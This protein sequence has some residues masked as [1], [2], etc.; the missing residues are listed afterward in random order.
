MINVLP[1]YRCDSIKS[2]LHKYNT[3]FLNELRFSSLKAYFR[4]ERNS[5]CNIKAAYLLVKYDGKYVNILSKIRSIVK[6]DSKQQF[7]TKTPSLFKAPF[8][9]TSKLHAKLLYFPL[10]YDSY[11]ANIFIKIQARLYQKSIRA[12][13]EKMPGTHRKVFLVYKHAHKKLKFT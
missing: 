2:L 10:K 11:Y 5:K 3:S 7:C 1:K 6:N 13:L 4:I 8:R 9:F 12:N